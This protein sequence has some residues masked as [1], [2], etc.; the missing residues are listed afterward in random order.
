[1]RI[2]SLQKVMECS[3]WLNECV[4]GSRLGKQR[5]FL[6]EGEERLMQKEVQGW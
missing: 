2:I 3:I 4:L 6:S 1:M 5:D